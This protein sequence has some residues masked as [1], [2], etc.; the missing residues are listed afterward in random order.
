MLTC[1]PPNSTRVSS[2]VHSSVGILACAAIL[3]SQVAIDRVRTGLNQLENEGTSKCKNPSNSNVEYR[4]GAKS[5]ETR[6]EWKMNVI[7]S[8]RESTT[9]AL[10]C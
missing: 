10:Y 6:S 1:H 4:G 9:Q 2:V 8:Q 7:S 5:K 3:A